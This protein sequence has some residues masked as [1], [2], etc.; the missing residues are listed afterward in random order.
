MGWLQRALGAGVD[1]LL[2]PRCAACGT[3]VDA[4]GSFCLKCWSDLPFITAPMCASC[5]LPFE[6]PQPESRQCGACLAKPPRYTARAALAY[7]GPA[8]EIVLRLK[9]SDRQHLAADMAGHLRRAAGELPDDAL[10]VPVPLHR[11][12]L[13][14]RGYNQAAEL[15]KALSKATGKPLLVDVL[16]RHRATKSSQGLNPTQ[17]R[18]NL[19][20]A[21]VLNP[22]AKPL[23]AAK[24]IILVDDVLTTGATANACARVL[25]RGGATSVRLLALARVVR[26]DSTGHIAS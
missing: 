16:V 24:C 1:L 5:G 3:I 26:P 22:R 20:G 25:L 23:I 2:P 14:R 18:R 12:R 13:W 8:R 6:T 10:I 17:R 21:F 15:A 19:A 7:E 4:Q 11:W 9:H